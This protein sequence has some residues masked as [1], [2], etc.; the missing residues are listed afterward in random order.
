MKWAIA[1]LQA[2]RA[3]A[4]PA[5]FTLGQVSSAAFPSELVASPGGAKLAWVSNA[6]GVRTSMIAEAPLY[7]GRK[8]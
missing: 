5:P 3:S 8:E 4:Q 7:K 2:F 6:K 1:I